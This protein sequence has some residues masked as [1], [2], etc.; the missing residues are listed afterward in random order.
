MIFRPDPNRFLDAGLDSLMI[1]EMSSQIQVEVGPST[2]SPPRSCSITHVFA[3][4]VIIWSRHCPTD[5][6]QDQ[7]PRVRHRLHSIQ[8][9][10]SADT[11]QIASTNRVHD[12]RAGS[13]GTDEGTRRLRVAFPTRLQARFTVLYRSQT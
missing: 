5:E 10:R 6:T 3:T 11:I 2:R 12:R 9:A 7:W 4:L 1:V 13:G 8:M